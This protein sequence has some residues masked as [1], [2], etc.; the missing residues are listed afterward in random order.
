[1]RRR[2][3]GLRASIQGLILTARVCVRYTEGRESRLCL[4]LS[5]SLGVAVL[6]GA[7]L[8]VVWAIYVDIRFRCDLFRPGP[9]YD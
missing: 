5:L 9:K 2:G 3:P 6:L 8:G 7:M 4:S 1:M